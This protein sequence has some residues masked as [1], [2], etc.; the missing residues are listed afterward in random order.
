MA[1]NQQGG[2]GGPW[3]SGGGTNG[4]RGG[5]N[6]PWGS[7]RGP[8]RPGGG[9]TPPPDIDELIR[10]A[11][12]RF[13]KMVPGGFGFGG[14]AIALLV[15]AVLAIWGLSGI[16]TVG[17]AERGVVLRFGKHVRDE[18]PGLRY[19]LPYPIETVLLPMVT[20]E[21]RIE[22]GVE[23]L[24]NGQSRFDTGASLMLTG[25]ENI[26][27]IQF[28]VVWVIKDPAAYLFNL[29][30]PDETVRW[31]AE[32]AMRE[33][34]G[35][36]NLQRALTDGRIDIET[37]TRTILQGLMDEYGSGIEIRR[38]QVQKNAPPS[39][40]GDAFSQ[41]QRARQQREQKALEAQ[42]R[43]NQIIPVARGER[44]AMIEAAEAYKE[45]VVLN[46]TGNAQRFSAIYGAYK[47]NPGITRSR[48]YIETMEQVFRNANKLVTDSNAS[49]VVPYLALPELQRGQAGAQMTG[50]GAQR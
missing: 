27:D 16:Y 26:I 28:S 8:R 30:N 10:Q 34:V 39:E 14:G 17:Q 18:D 1:W 15:L 12:E 43:S 9:Q 11:S 25:D 33:V 31:A 46:A 48:I 38:L 20:R 49:G 36:M 19:H 23:T 45:S 5:P 3:G 40:V 37:R 21:N 6:D 24:P 50:T 13:R 22:F 32:S 29:R 35:Q 44:A 41:V 42:T 7:G 2:G 47:G 4:G